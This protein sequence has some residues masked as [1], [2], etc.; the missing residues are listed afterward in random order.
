MSAPAYLP[1]LSRPQLCGRICALRSAL[2]AL[3]SQS[4]VDRHGAFQATG[5]L[6]AELIALETALRQRDANTWPTG[7]VT[8]PAAEQRL[9]QSHAEHAGV[10]SEIRADAIR[11]AHRAAGLAQTAR[12]RELGEMSCVPMDEV[13]ELEPQR[14]ARLGIG[15]RRAR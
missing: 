2:D 13:L 10:V 4:D 14:R 5:A 6:K 15:E 11:A 1:S 8:V 9:R 3:A 7:V 12:I